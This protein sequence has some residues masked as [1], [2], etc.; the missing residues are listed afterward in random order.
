MQFLATV[1]S[2]LDLPTTDNS[3]EVPSKIFVSRDISKKKLAV[4]SMSLPPIEELG[5]RH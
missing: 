1:R 2:L 3:A 5:G 4:L